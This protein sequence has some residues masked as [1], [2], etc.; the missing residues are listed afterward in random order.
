MNFSIYHNIFTVIVPASGR[1]KTGL[2]VNLEWNSSFNK[3]IKM[4]SGAEFLGDSDR[5]EDEELVNLDE[6]TCRSSY[7]FETDFRNGTF[8]TG[9]RSG[10][11]R[12]QTDL[13]RSILTA[14]IRSIDS[15]QTELS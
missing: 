5:E 10:L 4:A 11:A 9:M 14:L 8:F 12:S 3:K 7:G 2:Y 6:R 13:A 1:T 15:K